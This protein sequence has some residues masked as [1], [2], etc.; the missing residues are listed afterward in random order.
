MTV[1]VEHKSQIEAELPRKVIKNLSISNK[2]AL[3]GNVD[4]KVLPL[5]HRN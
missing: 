3:S 2:I 5:H 1:S 4:K